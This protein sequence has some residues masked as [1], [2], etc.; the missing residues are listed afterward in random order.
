[1]SGG[2]VWGQAVS[3]G[4][5]WGA[6][7]VRVIQGGGVALDVLMMCMGR[8]PA[9]RGVLGCG[10]ATRT[11]LRRHIVRV[12]LRRYNVIRSMSQGQATAWRMMC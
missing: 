8:H 5:V 12:A 10:R 6:G 2:V 11:M 7:A 9:A 3:G 4:V 1:M